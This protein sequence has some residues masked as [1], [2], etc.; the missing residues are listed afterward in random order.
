MNV[1]QKESGVVEGVEVCDGRL[2]CVGVV[3]VWVTVLEMGQ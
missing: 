2:G 3:K 1:G